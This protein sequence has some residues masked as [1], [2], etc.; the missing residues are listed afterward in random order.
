M[1]RTQLKLERKLIKK[2]SSLCL[3]C[4]L[5][6]TIIWNKNHYLYVYSFNGFDVIESDSN[7]V[8]KWSKTT[9]EI[10]RCQKLN[11]SILKNIIKDIE[12]IIQ[13][14]RKKTEISS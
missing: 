5:R 11:I 2:I 4:S 12:E 10:T 14:T 8:L 7:G 6:S 9:N 1:K 13:K 3:C